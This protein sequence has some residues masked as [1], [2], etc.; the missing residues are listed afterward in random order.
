MHVNH[1]HYICSLLS[2]L[3]SGEVPHFNEAQAS[4]GN[5]VRRGDIS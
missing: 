5:Q 2:T 4:S 1:T 3:P